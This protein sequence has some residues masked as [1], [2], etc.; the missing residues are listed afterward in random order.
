MDRL[1]AIARIWQSASNNHAHGVVQIRLLHLS[2][3]IDLT[4]KT[5]FHRFTSA[6]SSQDLL[7][8]GV[9]STA[10]LII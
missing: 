2:L 4:D 9:N 8:S 10:F 7:F 3:D 1:Q 5:Y 6:F